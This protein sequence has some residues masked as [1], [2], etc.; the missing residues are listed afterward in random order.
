MPRRRDDKSNGARRKLRGVDPKESKIV[1]WE[2]PED[3]PLDDEDQFHASKDKIL[4]DGDNYGEIDEGDEDEVFALKG[5]P[6]DSEDE[7][8]DD[9]DEEKAGEDEGDED[10]DDLEELQA[11]QKKS[12]KAEDKKGKKGKKGKAAQAP[13]SSASDEGSEEEEGWGKNKSAYYSSNAAQIESDDE[14]ANELEEQEAKRLQTKARE[15]LADE[16]FG[17]GDL[18]E[19]AA[20]QDDV[21]MD[22]PA[23]AVQ[24]LPQDKQSLL[25][26]LEKTSPE[27]LALAR[28]W[29]DVAHK[30]VQTQI[31]NAQIHAKTA[32]AL[33][34]GMA[35]LHYQALI[36]YCTTLAFY[37]HLRSQEKYARRPELLRSHPIFPRLLTLKQS[38]TTLEDL[39]LGISSDD[40]DESPPGEND[41]MVDAEQRWFFENSKG[42]ELG[43]L[44]EL[45][46]QADF[47]MADG[48][49]EDTMPK[50]K[51]KPKKTV[52]EEPPKKRRKT[53]KKASADPKPTVPVF[54]LIEPDMSQFKS[55][56]S[57]SRHDSSSS[58][59]VYGE[60]TA[61][62]SADA[63]DKQA[64]KKSLRFHAA[65]IES[66]SARRH[67]ARSAAMGGDDD[68]P[69][70]ERKKQKEERLLREAAAKHPGQGGDDLDDVEPEPRATQTQKEKKKRARESDGESGSDEGGEDGYYELVQRA[71]KERKEKKKAEYEAARAAARPD[72]DES[73]A[74]GPRA[75]TR[76]I[77]KNKGLTPHRGKSVRN[78]RVK[79][80]Q[81]FEKAKK[82][83]AS[84]KAV[85][86]GGIGATGVYGGEKSGITR[87]VKSIRL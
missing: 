62:D 22:A 23:S 63:A 66:T 81:R 64:R 49:G 1:R 33:I 42:L 32:D 44:E 3:I 20:E 86:K 76:A 8:E 57:K 83:V 75:L 56:S 60:A 79:K 24:P 77:L 5:I 78:P 65:R 70:R 43:E 48:D 51:P 41:P 34:L 85:Y 39:N 27:A 10:S 45:L 55:T 36:T 30:L 16:D 58:A 2:R 29:D 87:V 31:I 21:F 26:H 68:I 82:K 40:E 67:S 80:R 69:Y 9:D 71:S 15:A 46:Q 35:H 25:R 19:G 11:L 47:M 73:A 17:L 4:L 59:D 74:D 54:D 53:E 38:L 28:D 7:D 12:K 50:A 37:L 6:D 14:E 13:P 61:L 84:Q 72:I 52:I 18:V